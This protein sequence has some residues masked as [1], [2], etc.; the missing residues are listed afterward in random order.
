MLT[1]IEENLYFIKYKLIEIESLEVRMKLKAN[2]ASMFA[3]EADDKYSH[4][5]LVSDS[6][7]VTFSTIPQRDPPTLANTL[8]SQRFL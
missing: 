2:M 7:L 4:H 5:I 3:W 8:T 1:H 6:S